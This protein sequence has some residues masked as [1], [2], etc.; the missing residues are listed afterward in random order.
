MPWFFQSHYT[1][2]TEGTHEHL[3]QFLTVHLAERIKTEPSLYLQTVRS[4]S[5]SEKYFSGVCKSENV[6]YQ[7]YLHHSAL[8][9]E[10]E[11]S[12]DYIRQVWGGL[13]LSSWRRMLEG[14][15]TVLSYHRCTDF[16]VTLF[17]NWRCYLVIE[18]VNL[19][20]SPHDHSCTRPC[21]QSDTYWWQTGIHHQICFLMFDHWVKQRQGLK[22]DAFLKS[23]NVA[24][25]V[26]V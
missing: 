12:A 6:Y 3:R 15:R 21:Q 1:Q 7:G 9:P 22:Q 2:N 5:K 13:W 24:C 25:A 18:P 11:S 26:H 23:C 4:D 19:T 17:H 14:Q 20:P 8:S 16:P 10:D